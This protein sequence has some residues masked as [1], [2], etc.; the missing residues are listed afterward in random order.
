MVAAPF[1]EHCR[2][3]RAELMR[4]LKSYESGHFHIGDPLPG[5]GISDRTAAFMDHLRRLIVGYDAIIMT[6]EAEND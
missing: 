4:H 5:G 1:L 3:Q 6:M 2:H